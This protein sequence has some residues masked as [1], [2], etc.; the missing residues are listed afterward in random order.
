VFAALSTIEP[1]IVER[2]A[3]GHLERDEIWFEQRL[4]ILEDRISIR[5]ADL[6]HRLGKADWLDGAFSAGDL[7]TV[8]VLRRLAGSGLLEN[9]P[10]LL[11]LVARGEARPA[12]K[13]AFSAQLAYFKSGLDGPQSTPPVHQK[14]PIE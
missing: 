12:F 9:Y 2:E 13:R 14:E 5:L 7:M 4:S 11:A 1:P 10:N 6:S 8:D 3:A